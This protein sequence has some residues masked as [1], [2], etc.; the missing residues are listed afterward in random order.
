MTIIVTPLLLVALISIDVCHQFS[1]LSTLPLSHLIIIDMF[2]FTLL[3]TNIV[4]E[5]QKLWNMFK[6]KPWFSTSMLACP[7]VIDIKHDNMII[8]Y[9]DNHP[10]FD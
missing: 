10:M 2:F 5:N 8:D 9:Y 3:Q 7:S 6:G 4:V 1:T